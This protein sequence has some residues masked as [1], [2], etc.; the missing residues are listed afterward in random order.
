MSESPALNRKERRARSAQNRA[1][2]ARTCACCAPGRAGDGEH[3]ESLDKEL[4]RLSG[5]SA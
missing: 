1:S 5:A 2:V 4:P 3:L